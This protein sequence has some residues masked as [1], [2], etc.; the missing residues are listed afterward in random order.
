MTHTSCLSLP[1]S[2]SPSLSLSLSPRFS[3]LHA[4]SFCLTPS[5]S[6]ALRH[7]QACVVSL[8]PQSLF[9]VFSVNRYSSAG[10][11]RQIFGPVF[12]SLSTLSLFNSALTLLVVSLPPSVLMTSAYSSICLSL[13]DKNHYM[14]LPSL[15]Y[16]TSDAD[17]FL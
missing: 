14:I 12:S 10:N 4:L 2:F 11:L 8:L 9:D 7:A 17:V 6:Y 1:P 15:Y 16:P 3:P 13:N 5:P